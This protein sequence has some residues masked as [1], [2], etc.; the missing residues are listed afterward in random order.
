[1]CAGLRPPLRLVAGGLVV[2]AGLDEVGVDRLRELH[3]HDQARGL[4]SSFPIGGEGKG[5][6]DARPTVCYTRGE[7]TPQQQ[8]YRILTKRVPCAK[9]PACVEKHGPRRSV[10]PVG[11]AKLDLPR[12]VPRFSLNP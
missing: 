8:S 2:A 10:R 6:R 7:R 1:M 3:L 11:F 9:V 4:A 5:K 12:K